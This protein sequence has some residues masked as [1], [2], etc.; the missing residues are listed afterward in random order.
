MVMAVADALGLGE[1]GFRAG[2]GQRGGAVGAGRDTGAQV[3]A[4][5]GC[6]E[7]GLESMADRWGRA[8]CYG[9][10]RGSSAAVGGPGGAP[11]PPWWSYGVRRAGAEREGELAGAGGCAAGWAARVRASCTACR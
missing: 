1:D 6:R 11:G 10:L 4:E 5:H 9:L 8:G 7:S 3:A 2:A